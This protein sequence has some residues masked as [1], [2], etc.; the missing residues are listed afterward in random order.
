MAYTIDLK[1]GTYFGKN[2]DFLHCNAYVNLF[3]GGGATSML[4]LKKFFTFI[5]VF[6]FLTIWQQ[7][8]DGAIL[9]SSTHPLT[10]PRLSAAHKTNHENTHSKLH[11]KCP[12]LELFWPAFSCIWTE[13][14]ER[15]VQMR[16]NVDYNNS[17]FGHFLSSANYT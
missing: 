1:T 17:E 4:I 14:R 12:Y 2:C 8:L 3:K 5:P 6:N 11:E 10:A 15:R 16:E 13:Y 9:L 7:V